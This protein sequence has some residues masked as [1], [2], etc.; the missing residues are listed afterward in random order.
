ML[1]EIETVEREIREREDQILEE[2]EQ[3]EVLAAELEVAGGRLKEN[4]ERHRI[5]TD[6]LEQRSQTLG[7]AVRK[8]KGIVHPKLE[9]L[10]EILHNQIIENNDSRILVFC[11]FRDSVNNIV[12]YIER[13]G[14]IKAHKFVEQANTSLDKGLTQKKQI[15]LLEDFKEGIYN[16]L[17]STS[18]GEEGLDIAECDLVI[19]Y[20]IIPSAVRSIQR[21]GRTG[22]KKEGKVL[23]LMA[24]GTRDEGYYWAERPRNGL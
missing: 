11:H 14:V 21:R 4:E 3:T 16:T 12:N 5:E 22:R 17:I 6:T 18:V 9:K 23:L 24:E 7:E 15:E 1:H 10:A 19:F 20:D 2:M 13:D 8:K